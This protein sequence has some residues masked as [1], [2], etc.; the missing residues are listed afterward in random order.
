MENFEMYKKSKKVVSDERFKAYD[1]LYKKL[2]TR[3]VKDIF[4]LAKIR[5]KK[6]KTR[7]L[8]HVRCI[9]SDDQKVV[10]KDI[11]NLAKIRKRK[12][13]SRGLRSYQLYKER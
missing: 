3:E 2:E 7:D 13:K 9:K 10:R 8:D 1:N 6:S 12:R 11:F 4:N 5:K